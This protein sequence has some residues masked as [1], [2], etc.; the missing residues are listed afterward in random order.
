MASPRKSPTTKAVSMS[1]IA[2]G[3]RVCLV[4]HRRGTIVSCR[5]VLCRRT[6]GVAEEGRGWGLG[7]S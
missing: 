1:G 2:G 7:L 6:H 4:Q 5:V 3:D